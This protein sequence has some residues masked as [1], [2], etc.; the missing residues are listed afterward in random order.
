MVDL[1]TMSYN[2]TVNRIRRYCHLA[3]GVI[4]YN[5]YITIN[6]SV[7]RCMSERIGAVIGLIIIL[8][9]SSGIGA[10]GMQPVTRDRSINE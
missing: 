3:R 5:I 2:R 10:N 7:G 6:R 9:I 8:E 1:E 4:Y